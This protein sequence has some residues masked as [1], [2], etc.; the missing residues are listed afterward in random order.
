MAPLHAGLRAGLARGARLVDGWSFPAPAIGNFGTDYALRASVALGALA[1][2]E[3]AEAIYLSAQADSTGAPLAGAHRYRVAIPA[4][5]IATDAFWS[6][7]MY[8]LTPDGRL[9]FVDN[10]IR[11][12][13][14]GDRTRELV[15]RADGSI[16]LWV[17]TEA[18]SSADVGRSTNW[19]PCPTGAFRLV[20][21]AYQPRP[22]LLLGRAPLPRIERVG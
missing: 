13:A 6:L 22:D 11:R 2:L 9:F 4:G 7:S 1:A 5:G 14:V 21:R 18:P 16:D 19:L 3:P 12:Y 10:P 20:L 15:R 17:Q 8:E